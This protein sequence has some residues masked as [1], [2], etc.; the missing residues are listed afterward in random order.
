[1]YQHTPSRVATSNSARL[2]PARPSS[3]RPTGSSS[4]SPLENCPPYFYHITSFLSHLPLPGLVATTITVNSF[5]LIRLSRWASMGFSAM[6]VPLFFCLLFSLVLPS[7]SVVDSHSA[8]VSPS[9]SSLPP[10]LIPLPSSSS[11]V[12]WC[13]LT[14]H[15]RDA[16][17]SRTAI[18]PAYRSQGDP[19]L[20][21]CYSFLSFP[22][23]PSPL[24]R[25]SSLPTYAHTF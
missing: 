17:I 9:V 8:F 4:A 12:S 3:A 18:L 13:G 19:V 7:F 24:P 15:R 5:S 25:S 16:K 20:L 6:P 21:F 22:L 1:M 14:A 11:F 23:S 10:F 2:G